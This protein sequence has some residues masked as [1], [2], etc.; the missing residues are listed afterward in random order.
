[1]ENLESLDIKEAARHLQRSER[2]VRRYLQA[3]RLEH[4]KEPLP[5]GGFRYL[6]SRQ[7]LDLLKTELDTV[8]GRHAGVDMSGLDGLTAHLQDLQATVQAQ[9]DQIG[10]QSDQISRLAA[11]VERLNGQLEQA[12]KALPPAPRDLALP[13]T[14]SEEV[15]PAAADDLE[16]A[17]ED[18]QP[19]APAD[20]QQRRSASWWRRLLRL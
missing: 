18:H 11:E 14:A 12:I 1:M 2:S 16:P 4:S 6:I 7:S 15:E 20:H 9:A 10:A 17:P 3:G 19:A 8:Q 5:A 13:A